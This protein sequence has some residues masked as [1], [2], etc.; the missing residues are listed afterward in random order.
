MKIIELGRV[1]NAQDPLGLGRIR[2]EF[3]DK[4]NSS[5]EKSVPNYKSWD[6]NDPFMFY[7]FLPVQVNII[8]KENQ[9][10]KLV[11]W[12]TENNSLNKE[13]ISG[14]YVN[15]FDFPGQGIDRQLQS[16]S[17]GVRIK[18]EPNIF[19]E[20]GELI[21][22]NTKGVVPNPGDVASHGNYGTDVLHTRN[23]I[24]LRAGKL[25]DEKYRKTKKPIAY[26]K[27]ARISVKKYDQTI[28]LQN[29]DILDDEPQHLPITTIVEYLV[30]DI[31][32]TNTLFNGS[33]SVYKIVNHIYNVTDT[34]NFNQQTQVADSSK[35]LIYSKTYSGI[36]LEQM[37]RE[38]SQELRN[39]DMS[40]TQGD[41][42]PEF[43]R[44]NTHPFYYKPSQQFFDSLTTARAS[45]NT[46]TLYDYVNLGKTK[47]FGLSYSTTEKY[48]PSKRVKKAI[49]VQNKV[50]KPTT[51]A[52]MIS[53][54]LYLLA[55]EANTPND[56]DKI[57]FAAL[58]NYELSQEELL[59]EVLPKTF[60]GVRGEPLLYLIELMIKWMMTHVHNPA[61]PG[62]GPEGLKEELMKEIQSAREKIINQKLRIN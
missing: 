36:T 1:V 47:A 46:K 11:F 8:P 7:P 21:D 42:N 33:I 40:E 14:P 10:V 26:K 57:N 29:K 12:D 22:P 23:G 54:M 2:I 25:D 62:I 6:D 55:Y 41:L 59:R 48:V 38:F 28:E 18:R 39:I 49:V 61:E 45:L 24:T 30:D 15:A 16:T 34:A 37:G 4:T 20:N 35:A 9:V 5:I 17:K 44:I 19:K 56:A 13:Y 51:V 31:G 52:T 50:D 3:L 60:S 43:Y 32:S 53:D 58:S 27:L